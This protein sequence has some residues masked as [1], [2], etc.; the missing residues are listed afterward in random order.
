MAT[1]AEARL[2]ILSVDGGGL[3]GL[4]PALVLRRPLGPV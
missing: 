3:R 2:R 1:V 4:V